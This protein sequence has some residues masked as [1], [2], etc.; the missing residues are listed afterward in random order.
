MADLQTQSPEA[1]YAT[2]GNIVPQKAYSAGRTLTDM[3]DGTGIPNAEGV[4][5]DHLPSGV[6]IVNASFTITGEGGVA[7]S[8]V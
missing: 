2:K 7:T 4:V 3:A 6:G 5:E 8:G 1:A